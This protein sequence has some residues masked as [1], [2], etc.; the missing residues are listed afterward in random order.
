M[1]YLPR[2]LSPLL[3]FYPCS[4]G[5]GWL[6]NL[7]MSDGEV[8][9]G[10]IVRS[11]AG[12]L[13]RTY[14]DWMYKHLYLYREYEPLNTALFRRLV[15]PGDTCLDI[16]ANFGYFSCLFALSGARVIGFEP[17]PAN[18]QLYL[19]TIRLNDLDGRVIPQNIG[20]GAAVGEFTV[21]TFPG[22][23]HGAASATR[24]GRQDAVA[25][26]CRL[27]TL[28]AFRRERGLAGIS[29]IKTDV[30][31]HELDVFRG[32]AET[33]SAADAPIVHFEV[34]AR[35]LEDRKINPDELLR[36]LR[37]YGYTAFFEIGHYGG[38]RPARK[39]LARRNADYL[40]LKETHV[41]RLSVDPRTC[42]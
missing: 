8:P 33:L 4:F 39:E 35:C 21:Y 18:F 16:G 12:V 7:L 34:N 31:G 29:F 19:E 40:A 3:R 37:S 11:K 42:P 32:G 15:R 2:L 26:A 38:L 24:L 14:P 36:L 9:N 17:L 10:V 5:K 6:A 13:V 23:P 27:T 22:E 25:H 30:E 28:D 41:S 1:R 20:L